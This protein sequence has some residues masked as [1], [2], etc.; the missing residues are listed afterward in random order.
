MRAKP[1]RAPAHRYE[2]KPACSTSSRRRQALHPPEKVLTEKAD[3]KRG[4]LH[5]GMLAGSTRIDATY[6]TPIENHNP[7][8]TARDHRA[9]GRRPLTLHDSTQYMKGVQRTVAATLGIPEENVT[10]ICPYVGGGFG[11]KG[12]VW[13]HVVLAAMAARQAGPS[14]QAGAGP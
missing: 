8:E 12:S 3:T 13:S 1:R 9:V 14:R 2:R 10:A 4:D 6:T 5:A 11:C 7:L